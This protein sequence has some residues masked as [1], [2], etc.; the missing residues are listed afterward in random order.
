MFLVLIE[1]KKLTKE[2]HQALIS[3]EGYLR[4]KKEILG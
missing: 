1:V 4:L 3:T 2:L